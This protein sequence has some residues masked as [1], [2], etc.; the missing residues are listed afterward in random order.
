MEHRDSYIKYINSDAISA[1]SFISLND[2]MEYCNITCIV[3]F[4]FLDTELTKSLCLKK[5]IIYLDEMKYICY[6]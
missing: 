2:Y 6:E 4:D 5:W 3:R 1:G